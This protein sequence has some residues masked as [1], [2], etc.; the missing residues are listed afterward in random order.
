MPGAEVARAGVVAQDQ[1]LAIDGVKVT[2][3]EDIYLTSYAPG[4]IVRLKYAH[5]GKTKEVSVAAGCIAWPTSPDP[6]AK[7]WSELKQK[8]PLPEIVNRER[9]L[10]ENSLA[11]K[12]LFAAWLHYGKGLAAY[13]FW[14]EG[15][16]NNALIAK[17]LQLWGYAALEMKQYL[18]LAPNASDAQAARDQ[19]IIWEEKAK[20]ATPAATGRR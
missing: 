13:P 18:L 3:V 20:E 11:E 6:E 15:W 1:I 4:E 9:V 14:P 16:Y 8:P 17:E 10:A 12:N 19:I 7:A 5:A 2:K